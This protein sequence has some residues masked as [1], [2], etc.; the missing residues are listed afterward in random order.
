MSIR[1]NFC[2]GKK[3][4]EEDKYLLEIFISCFII[5]DVVNPIGADQR[6]S[7]F[8]SYNVV[9]LVEQKIDQIRPVLACCASY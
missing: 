4:T 5:Q 2:D 9:S 3:C 6:S 8:D 7:S 1:K